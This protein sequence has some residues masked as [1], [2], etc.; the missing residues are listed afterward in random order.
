MA[1][2]LSLIYIK[3]KATNFCYLLS[4]SQILKFCLDHTVLITIEKKI[5]LAKAKADIEIKS[6]VSFIS[7]Q[8]KIFL[9][10]TDNLTCR[11]LGENT[12]RPLLS[13]TF[14]I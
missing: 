11:K 14:G 4:T 1:Y 9:I 13:F 5:K 7:S 6:Y 2:E 10:L 8:I 3:R 12:L